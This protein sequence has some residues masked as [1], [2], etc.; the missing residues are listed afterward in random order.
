MCGIGGIVSFGSRGVS[1]EDIDLIKDQLKHRGPDGDGHFMDSKA[2]LVHTRL[3]IIDLSEKGAQPFYK[4][5][6]YPS[7]INGELYNYRLIRERLL[8]N[9]ANFKGESDAEI[10]PHLF[11]QNG[12]SFIKEVEGMFAIATWDEEAEKLYLYRD[13]FGIKPLYYTWQNDTFYFGSE[14]KAILCHDEVKKELDTQAIHDYL[15]LCYVPEP[16]TGFK[17]IQMLLPGHVLEVSREGVEVA[18]YWEFGQT[19]S[20]EDSENEVLD[21]LQNELD[22]A[23]MAQTVSDAPLGAF[24]SGGI[25]SST[26]VNSLSKGL[27]EGEL[28]TFTVKFP[29]KDFDE[30]SYAKRIS[31]I[32]KTNHHEFEIKQGEGDPELVKRLVEHFDQ[33]FADSSCIPTFLISQQ[34]REKVKVALS[35]DGGDEVMAGYHQFWYFDYIQRLAKFPKPLIKLGRSLISVFPLGVDRKRQYQKVM[36]LALL[37]EAEL[38]CS[39][40]SYLD[41]NQKDR[42]YILKPKSKPTSR[43]FHMDDFADE[44]NYQKITKVLFKTS[45]TGDMLKKVDMMSMLAK[46][47]VR[48]PLLHEHYVNYAITVPSSFKMKDRKGKWALRQLLK[49]ALPEDIVEKKKSGFAIPLDKLVNPKMEEFIRTTLLSEDAAISQFLNQ[50]EIEKWVNGFISGKADRSSYSREGLYQRIFMMLSLELW[51]KK[52]SL[53]FE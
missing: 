11:A 35:G 17:G 20:S 36:D 53:R 22:G 37:N 44:T 39:L 49:R 15:S 10:V 7:I 12:K 25:D 29:D 30:S 23:V 28:K 16:A 27:E 1:T 3:S 43:L 9:G 51:M 4:D 26:V 40:G 8:K 33:P 31:E 42:L 38:L 2:A 41:E 34:I 47:E 13:R 46:I 48:V 5:S 32:L 21:K 24:L 18:P 52:Y 50:K 45:L 14:L 19:Q 6:R